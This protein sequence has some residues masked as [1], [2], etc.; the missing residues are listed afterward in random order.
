M[1]VRHLDKLFAPCSVAVIGATDRPS[2]VGEVVMRTLLAGGFTGPIMP[3]NPRREVLFGQAC[4]P[5]VGSLPQVPD[6]AVIC[7][8][9]ATVPG[10]ITE[11]GEKGTR[12]A[13]VITAGV[14]REAMLNAARPYLLRILGHNC[15]GLL[16]PG[17]GL[18]ASF[19]PGTL[20]AGDRL[21]APDHN[22]FKE[23]PMGTVEPQVAAD[24]VMTDGFHL[25]IDALKLNGIDTIFGLPGIP[26]TDFAR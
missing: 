23:D 25:V 8:P 17:I 24:V 10:L 11:L 9:A 14:D 7:T 4:H 3:V 20:G 5:D 16:V 15:V 12:A 2:A 1:S 19:A 22:K 21:F 13:V 26:I 6:L 18:N